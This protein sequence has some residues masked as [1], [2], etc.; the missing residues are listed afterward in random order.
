[1]RA[2]EEQKGCTAG[3]VRGLASFIAKRLFTQLVPDAHLWGAWLGGAT[4]S[5]RRT[6]TPL[7][8]VVCLDPNFHVSLLCLAVFCGNICVECNADPGAANLDGMVASGANGGDFAVP[9]CVDVLTLLLFLLH[10]LC[11]SN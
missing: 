6:Y 2:Q 5:K 3:K 4:P 7:L 9:L 10:S 1:M 8:V 11:V